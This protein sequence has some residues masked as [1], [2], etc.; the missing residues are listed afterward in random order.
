MFEL[1]LSPPVAWT[2]GTVPYLIAYN[3]FSPHGSNLEGINSMSQLS[4]SKNFSMTSIL[5]KHINYVGKTF[6][7]PAVI[8][9]EIGTLNPTQPRYLSLYITS[10]ALIQFSYWVSPDPSITWKILEASFGLKENR[11]LI[12]NHHKGCTHIHVCCTGGIGN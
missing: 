3:W 6:N 1:T 8:L 4:I 7:Y 12:E 5:K 11:I 9:W 10:M 2:T